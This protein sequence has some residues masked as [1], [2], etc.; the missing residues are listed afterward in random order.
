MRAQCVAVVALAWTLAGA[1][2]VIGNAP[3]SA[4]GKWIVEIQENKM[5]GALTEVLTLQADEALDSSLGSGFPVFVI[6]CTG[7]VAKPK[8]LGSQLISPVLLGTPQI[9]PGLAGPH[10][11]QTVWQRSDDKFHIH[12]WNQA[13]DFKVLFVDRGAT[14]DLLNSTNT[15]IQFRDIQEHQEVAI[16]SPGGIDREELVKACGESF[17]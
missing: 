8:W 6:S 5:T 2:P 13:A 16:F 17:N 7:R 1:V 4:G 12:F 15:R 9:K 14:K 3:Q 10:P 11:Q